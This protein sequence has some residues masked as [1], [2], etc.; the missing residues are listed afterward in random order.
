MWN[1]RKLKRVADIRTL[2]LHATRHADVEDT[3]CKFLNWTEPPCRVITGNSVKMKKIV[4]EVVKKYGYSCYN[5]SS[6]NHGSLI[7]VEGHVN[8]FE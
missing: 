8:D 1:L 6:F 4:K 2:D 7:V 5:E 3:V